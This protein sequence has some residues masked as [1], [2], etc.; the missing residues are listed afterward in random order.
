M[1]APARGNLR[2]IGSRQASCFRFIDWFVFLAAGQSQER[3]CEKPTSD[4]CEREKIAPGWQQ[5][6]HRAIIDTSVVNRVAR[7]F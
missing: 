5:R 4:S 3:T 1:V 7:K 2:K 6:L